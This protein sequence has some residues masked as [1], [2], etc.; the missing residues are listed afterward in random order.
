MSAFDSI[1]NSTSSFRR[2]EKKLVRVGDAHGRVN[3]ERV[4]VG[5]VMTLV[6]ALA[7]TG[8]RRGSFEIACFEVRSL[9]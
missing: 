6:A 1:K 3:A 2:N 4:T 5:G 7:R 8:E 9:C